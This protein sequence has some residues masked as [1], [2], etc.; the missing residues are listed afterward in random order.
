MMDRHI[1]G[2][3]NTQGNTK[4]RSS[5]SVLILSGSRINPTKIQ[6]TKAVEALESVTIPV[7]E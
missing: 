3:L 7:G 6:Q 4:H 5:T 2:L 1:T